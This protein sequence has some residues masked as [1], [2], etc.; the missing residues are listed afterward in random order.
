MIMTLIQKTTEYY[1]EQNQFSRHAFTYYNCYK[2]FVLK[3]VLYFSIALPVVELILQI[4]AV[5][6]K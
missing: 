1:K 6:S 2:E 3:H 4:D 5:C